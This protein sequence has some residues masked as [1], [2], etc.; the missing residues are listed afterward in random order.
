MRLLF[1]ADKRGHAYW[2]ELS[3][4]ELPDPNLK[5]KRDGEGAYMGLVDKYELVAMRTF[6]AKHDMS[7]V[8]VGTDFP[9]FQ[10]FSEI[11]T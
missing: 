9:K 5:N 7:I 4:K 10:P 6:F 1:A 8:P 3:A 11:R 2:P